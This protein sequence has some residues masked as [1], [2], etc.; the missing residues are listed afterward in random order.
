MEYEKEGAASPMAHNESIFTTAAIDEKW[1]RDVMILG[2][3]WG[4]PTCRDKRGGY[5]ASERACCR[6]NGICQSRTVPIV[7]YT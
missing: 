5:H 6:N 4:V 1:A 3:P 7:H 2:I